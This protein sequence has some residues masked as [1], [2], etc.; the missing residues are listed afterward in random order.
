[1]NNL[2]TISGTAVPVATAQA[3]NRVAVRA[4]GRSVKRVSG[5]TQLQ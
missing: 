1:M 4:I 2:N 5:E 3:V